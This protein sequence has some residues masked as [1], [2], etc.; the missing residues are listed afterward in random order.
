MSAS[1]GPSACP[2]KASNQVENVLEA[3]VWGCNYFLRDYQRRIE[4]AR[5]APTCFSLGP[6]SDMRSPGM[7]PLSDTKASLL[8]FP[9]EG[10]P[11][12]N[13]V[14]AERESLGTTRISPFR[15]SCMKPLS[16]RILSE[17]RELIL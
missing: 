7:A 14:V 11:P 15:V 12:L 2:T 6:A 5:T 17:G 8:P 16:H 3:E 9:M 13:T 4:A 1:A 10:E